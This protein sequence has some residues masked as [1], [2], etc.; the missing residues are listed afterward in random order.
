MKQFTI[1]MPSVRSDFPQFEETYTEI[2]GMNAVEMTVSSQE[3]ISA[4][5][6]L[7]FEEIHVDNEG[8]LWQRIEDFHEDLT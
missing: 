3:D 7:L 8:R 6:V 5:D 1:R 4:I 2:I